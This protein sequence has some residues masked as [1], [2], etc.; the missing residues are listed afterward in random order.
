MSTSPVWTW[1]Y[2]CLAVICQKLGKLLPCCC[3][4]MSS[5][6]NELQHSG[7]PIAWLSCVILTIAVPSPCYWAICLAKNEWLEWTYLLRR[8]SGTTG[9]SKEGH[10]NHATWAWVSNEG[11]EGDQS[12]QTLTDW[13]SSMK[14]SW[15]CIFWWSRLWRSPNWKAVLGYSWEGEGWRVWKAIAELF[16]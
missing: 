9:S 10:Y 3:N 6:C 1:H 7:A 2:I 14:Q 4:L 11:T 16:T 15:A 8:Q 12:Q 5:S 13:H